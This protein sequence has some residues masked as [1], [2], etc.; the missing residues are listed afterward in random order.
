MHL[1]QFS[2]TIA[3][4]GLTMGA[5]ATMISFYNNVPEQ[6][7][8]GRSLFGAIV[9]FFSFY[10]NWTNILLVMI[11]L[12]I[13]FGWTR[14]SSAASGVTG[15]SS[16]IMVMIVY[17]FLLSAS[18]NPQGIDEITS[19]IMH[20]VTPVLFTLF[21]ITSKHTGA[22]KWQ[23]LYKFMVFPTAF[24]AFTYA[25]AAATG[26]YP[27]DFLNLSLNGIGGVA[28]VIIAIVVLILLL[29][30]LA[31]FYDNKVSEKT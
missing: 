23:D 28:P 11:Y 30:S 17:H 22:L 15:L 4:F 29:G 9:H 7:A 12:D 6:M 27:Y 10:T 1:T 31:I 8:D 2:K 3:I 16:I 21:W 14:L 5:L 13:L 19:V 25:K 20:Y 26:E 24:L 18:H